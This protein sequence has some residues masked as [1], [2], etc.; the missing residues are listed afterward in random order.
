MKTDVSSSVSQVKYLFSQFFALLRQEIGET[1][2]GKGQVG[3]ACCRMLCK[4]KTG[5]LNHMDLNRLFV[6][7]GYPASNR[8]A[9]SSRNAVFF[10]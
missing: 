9:C 10:R 7:I 6:F 4:T 2:K 8:D 5:G 3:G 1:G